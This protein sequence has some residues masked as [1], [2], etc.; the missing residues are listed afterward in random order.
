MVFSFYTVSLATIMEYN[1]TSTVTYT[2][3]EAWNLRYS[4]GTICDSTD[5]GWTTTLTISITGITA[6]RDLILEPM[7]PILLSQTVC[8]SISLFPFTPFI[9]SLSSLLRDCIFTMY[10]WYILSI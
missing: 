5:L 8:I 6:Q 1:G 9:R 10:I 4:L 7:K 3:E 2:D